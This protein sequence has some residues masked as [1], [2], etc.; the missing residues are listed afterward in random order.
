VK[1]SALTVCVNYADLL[2]RSLDRWKAGTEDLLVVTHPD[3]AATIALCTEHDV[4]FHATRVFHE[5]GA[6]FNKAGAINEALAH[7]YGPCSLGSADSWFLLFDADIIPPA[8][9]RRRLESFAQPLAP[10]NL[11]GAVR[12][13]E[14]G[15]R[16]GDTELAGFFQLFHC[17][18]WHIGDDRR[19]PILDEFSNCSAYDSLFMRRWPRERRIILPMLVTHLGEAGVNWCGRGN[20]KGMQELRQQR[21]E[22]GGFM[23]ERL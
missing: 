1:I 17:Q 2:S 11:Y 13:T 22:H 21:I 3:D 18:D 7:A 10:G 9:W 20:D 12:V 23:H 4:G 8:D 6:T 5:R 19:H 16:F 14:S 15:R